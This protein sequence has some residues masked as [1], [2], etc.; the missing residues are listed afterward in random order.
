MLLSL[1]LLFHLLGFILALD[2]LMTA[3]TSQGATA[4]VISLITLPYVAIPLY[5]FFG[6]SKF[7]GY[8]SARKEAEEVVAN[9]LKD[10]LTQVQKYVPQDA[11]LGFFEKSLQH[12]VKMPYFQANELELLIDGEK[13]FASILEGIAEAKEYVLLEFYIVRDD[14]LGRKVQQSLIKKAQEGIKIYFIYD[15]IGSHQL[16]ESYLNTMR[17]AK[18][19]VYNFHTQKGI[20]NRFQINFRNHRKIVIVDGITSWLGGLNI[21]DEYLSQKKKFG[22]WRDTHLK[23]TGPSTIAVQ[24]TFIEDWYWATEKHIENLRWTPLLSQKENKKVLIVPSS[25]SDIVETASLMYL[26]A[27][28]AATER[29]WISS[30]YFIPDRAIIKALQLAGLRGVDVRILIPAKADHILVYLAAFTYFENIAV[31]GVKFFRYNNGF[32]HQKVML[33]DSLHATVGTANMDNRS[34]RLNFEI[35]AL[36][37]DKAF[38]QEI[39][40][41]FEEDF[42]NSNALDIAQISHEPFLFKLAT[43]LARLTSPVL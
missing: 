18:I 35:S 15:E 40:M 13:T 42:Q 32:L 11:S 29:I 9:K 41:M 30:P 36:I 33:I 12:L 16:P 8:T 10:T 25:P 14:T 26:Q 31:T 37:S 4:W 2:A 17:E 22:H 27:I 1:L 43:R 39:K 5:W 6:R 20:K 21:G 7:E 24:K 19:E 3:R 38:A 23:L 28:N 34:F